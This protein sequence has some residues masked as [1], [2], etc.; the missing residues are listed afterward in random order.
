VSVAVPSLSNGFMASFT[1]VM[2]CLRS[3]TN[4]PGSAGAP[5]RV[6]TSHLTAST[7]SSLAAAARSSN[8][9]RLQLVHP[10]HNQPAALS[11]PRYTCLLLTCAL[12]RFGVHISNAAVINRSSARHSQQV[13]PSAC[14]SSRAETPVQDVLWTLQLDLSPLISQL[15]C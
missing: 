5:R 12:G 2:P 6:F 8:S 4:S 1:F 15:H 7:S 14:R 3:Q 11:H 13:T 10:S 9:S